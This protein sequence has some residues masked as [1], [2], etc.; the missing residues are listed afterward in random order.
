[1]TPTILKKTVYVKVKMPEVESL[2]KLYNLLDLHKCLAFSG[3]YEKIL[4]LVNIDVQ[5]DTVTTLIQFY[6]PLLR[7]FTFQ[8]FQLAPTC[9]SSLQE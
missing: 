6:D 9:L 1:M 5:V 7:C 2:K 8:D 3:K 4:N